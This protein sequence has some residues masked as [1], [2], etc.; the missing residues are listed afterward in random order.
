MVQRLD[1][2]ISRARGDGDLEVF[3]KSKPNQVGASSKATG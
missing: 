2:A 3:S 1:V